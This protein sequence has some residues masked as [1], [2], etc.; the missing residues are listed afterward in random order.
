MDDEIRELI[1]VVK[2]SNGNYELRFKRNNEILMTPL[3]YENA[4]RYLK[5]KKGD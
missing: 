4:Q 3:T 1:E 2:N 5:A